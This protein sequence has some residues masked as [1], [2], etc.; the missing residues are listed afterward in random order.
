VIIGIPKEI[1]NNEF[2][3]SATPA[4]VH[5]YVS[6]GHQVIVERSAGVGSGI[7]DYDYIKAGATIIDKADEL[8]QKADLI[9]KVKEPIEAEYKRMRSGQILYTYLHLAANKACTQ[10][11][12]DSGCTAIAYETVEVD[13][14][15]PLLAPMSEVAGRMSIQVGAAALEASK[16]GRGVLLGGVPGV[17]PG[18]VVVIGGGVVGVAAATIAHG[19]RADVTIMDLDLKRL[20]QIDQIFGGNVKTL[21]SSGYEI[22]KEVTQADLVIG[23]V[24][25]HG[26]KAPKLVSNDLVSKMRAGSV[27]VDV[28]IDQGGCFEDSR[29]TT[30][31]DPTYKVHNAI[32]YAVANMPGAVP[33]TSTY[34]LANATIKYGLALAN[35]GWQR[36]LADDA[37]L[38]KG[39]NVHEGR[40][41]YEAVAKAHNL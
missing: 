20:A 34:A 7:S 27:L 16:G 15:L 36:A 32:F 41:M 13:G 33:A 21:A 24:L 5:A 37:S 9:Q 11:I 3:V 2:R 19:M 12:M 1:K 17:R 38:A 8:W 18:K 22:E 6:A 35:K 26:A 4:G 25:V 29:P 23:A 10:A 14:A 39:L 31:Q 40:I 28:A 30:H